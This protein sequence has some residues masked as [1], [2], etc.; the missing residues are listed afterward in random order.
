[1]LDLGFHIDAASWLTPVPNVWSV[2]IR[3]KVCALCF[4][5]GKGATKKA[6]LAAALGEYFERLSSTSLCAEFWLGGRIATSACV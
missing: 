1:L 2:H 3:Y 4:P 6:A 5:N